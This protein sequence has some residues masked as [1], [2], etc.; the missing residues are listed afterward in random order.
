MKTELDS[1]LVKYRRGVQRDIEFQLEYVSVPLT[2]IV[3]AVN[4]VMPMIQAEADNHELDV[5]YKFYAASRGL[6][7]FVKP[8]PE[9]KPEEKD[10]KNVKSATSAVE[11]DSYEALHEGISSRSCIIT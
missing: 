11:D 7:V 3:D 6:W 1:A 5:T 4:S 2:T 10:V 8:K 9:D